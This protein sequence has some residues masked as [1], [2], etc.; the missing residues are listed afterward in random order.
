MALKQEKSFCSMV[1]CDTCM[2]KWVTTGSQINDERSREEN[3]LMPRK[4]KDIKKEVAGRNWRATI[5][6]Q[7]LLPSSLMRMAALM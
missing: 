2:N 6:I 7:R 4:R 5:A 1:M 3:N